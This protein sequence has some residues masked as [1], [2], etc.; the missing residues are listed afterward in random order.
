MSCTQL[1]FETLVLQGSTA[2]VEPKRVSL[3]KS[4]AVHLVQQDACSAPLQ[5][6]IKR[7]VKCQKGCYYTEYLHD[8]PIDGCNPILPP[9]EYEFSV[10]ESYIPLFNELSVS[11]GVILEDV[12]AEYIQAVIANKS[13]GKC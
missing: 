8:F 7:V 11:L 9:G 1:Q 3:T 10:A 5:L 4:A 13:G 12:S 6:C 2:P